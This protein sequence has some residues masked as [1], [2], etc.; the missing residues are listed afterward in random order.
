MRKQILSATL[1]ALLAASF[2]LTVIAQE[3]TAAATWYTEGIQSLISKDILSDQAK[4][5][6]TVPVKDFI[7]YAALSFTYQHGIDP[8]KAAENEGWITADEFTSPDAPITRGELARILVRAYD[9]EER[10]HSEKTLAEYTQRAKALGL[11]IGY[12]DGSLHE[13][14]NATIGEAASAL[15]NLRKLRLA[16]IDNKGVPLI[17][18]EDFMRNPGNF[19]YQLSTDGNHIS[20][21][22]PWESRMNVFVKK[23]DGSS[24]PTRVTSSK[25]RDIAGFFWKGDHILYL[26]DKGGDENY[27]LYSAAFNGNAEKDL[28]PFNKVRVGIVN[29]LSNVKDEILI[30]MNKDNAKAFDVYKL[31]VKTGATK[32]VAKNPGNIQAWIADHNGAIRMAV[33]SDGLEGAILYRDSED[34]EFKP[35][36]K[37]DSGDTVNPL[38]FTKDNKHIYA[39]TNKGRDKTALVQYDLQG[40]EQ[41]IYSHPE[42]DLDRAVYD[43]KQDKLLMASYVTDKT[44]LNFF[45][46]G[47]EAL[48]HKLQTKLHASE[49]EVHITDYNEDR[50]KFIVAVSTDKVQGKYYYYNSTTDQLTL[51]TTLSDW[52]KPK[53]LADMYPISYKSRDGLTIHGYLTLPKNKRPE[54]LPL[55]VNPHGGPWARDKWGF[56]PEVQLLANRGYAVLQMNFRSSTGYGKAF[57]DAGDKQWGR[58]IQNDI[59]DGVK[60]AIKQGIADP[61]RVGIYGASFGGYATLAGITFTP[62]L[63]AAAVDYVGVSNIFTLL[64]TLPPYWEAN[65][66]MFYAR[67]GHPEKDKELLKAASP[68]FHADKIITPLFVAQGAND[69]RVNK[70]ESDQIVDALK[71][72]GIDVQYMVKDNEGHGFQ[73]EENRIDFYNAMIK[74]LDTHLKK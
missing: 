8:L 26:K 60:W 4:P 66:N 73:N 54:N 33:A 70:A 53:N 49:S 6:S 43:D 56:N 19:S 7:R 28:T 12:P 51:L 52:L 16:Q 38:G 68:V 14:K 24:E 11:L 3:K 18:V 29:I 45:D 15:S 10:E 32:L 69:P 35:F 50:T 23:M 42:V 9:S 67:I 41:L 74:F 27:H 22:A 57:I 65:R 31:N 62:N 58:D 63:Y 59:T 37:I 20:Y 64:N 21:A 46:A 34:A 44:H 25:D 55:I 5:T 40:K 30:T 17:S 47:F 71:K 36:I 39:I 2:P 13:N 61:N 48:H 1:A 72:R